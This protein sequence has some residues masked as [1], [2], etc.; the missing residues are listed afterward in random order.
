MFHILTV[1][2]IVAGS[3]TALGVVWR[4]GLVPIY[5]FVRKIEMAHDLVLEFPIWQTEVNKSLKQLESNGGSSLKDVVHKTRDEVS[6]LKRL[7]EDH[8]NNPDL[9]VVNV[10]VEGR[11]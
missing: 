10:N 2:G 3:L 5:R 7:M 9:H 1:L 8:H 11:G 4:M 6:E